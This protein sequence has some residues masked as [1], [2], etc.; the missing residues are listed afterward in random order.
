NFDTSNLSVFGP[1]N[2]TS[3][4]VLDKVT[5]ADGSYTKFDYNG[6]AQVYKT[7]NYAQNDGLL[8]YTWRNIETPSSNQTDCPRFTQTKTKIANFNL[9]QYGAAQEIVY[10]NSITTNQSYSLPDSISG[11][12]TKIEMSMDNDPYSSV[13]KIFVGSSG[14]NEGLPIATEDWATENSTSSRKRWTW[15]NWTQDD[16]T[17]SYIVNP[18]VTETRVG[19]TTNTKKTQVDY[20]LQTGTNISTYGLTKEV[21][22]YDANLSTVLKTAKAE[23]IMDTAYTSR[24]IIGLPS[25]SELYEGTSTLMSKVTYAYDEGNFSDTTL[26]QNISPIQHND[27]NYSSSFITGRGNLTS[28]TRWD[29]NYPTTSSAAVTASVKYNTAGLPVAQID[30]L[31][32]AVQISYADNFNDSNN[33][34]NTYAYPTKI[35]EAANTDTNN[36]YSQV[37]Y[38][39]DIG[40]NVW[41]KSPKPTGNTSGK[42]TTREFDSIGRLERETIVNTDA[43]TRYEYPT[44]GVQSKVYSTVIDTNNNGADSSDEVL[45]E[46]WTDGAGRVRM[47]KTDNPGSTGGYTGAI[48]EYD[49]LGQVR[50][51]SVPTEISV[52]STTSEWTPAGDD[53]NRGW[54]WTYQKYDWKGR[55]T[56]IINTD[57][58]DS[59]TLNDSDQLFSYDGCGCAGGQVTTIE[60]ESVP[61][62]GQTYSARRKQKVYADILGRIYKTEIM[63][64]D[65]STVYT[66]NVNTYNGRDQMTNTRQYAGTTSSSTYQDVTMTY[67]GHGRM[68][69]RH[70][71]IEDANTYTAWNYN[72]DDSIDDVT[73]PRGA[74]TSFTYNSRGLVSG[75]GYSVPTGSGIP[76]PSDV[77]FTYDAVGNRTQ[78]TDGAGTTDYAYNQLSQIISETKDFADTLAD[79]PTSHYQIQYAYNL[80]G[81]LKSVTDPFGQ[82][83]DYTQDKTGRLTKVDGSSF[84]T[85]T[86]ATTSYADGIKYRAWGAVKELTYKTDDNA[87]VAMQYDNRFR[88][89]QYEVDTSVVSSGHMKKA[90]FS[91]SADS[92]PNT[93]TDVE[94][95]E[96]NRTFQYDHIG[97]LTSNTFGT[98]TVTPYT[99]TN[100]YDSFSQLTGRNTTHWYANNQFT[101]TFTNG[102]ESTSGIL[103]TTYDAAGNQTNTGSRGDSTYQTRE[104]DAANRVKAFVSNGKRRT[105]RF[106]YIT[107]KIRL[108]QDYDGDGHRLKQTEAVWNNSTTGWVDTKTS[109]Q[110]WSTVLGSYLSEMTQT[111]KKS[112]TKVFAGGAVIAEQVRKPGA[113]TDIDAVEW[114]HADPVS[115]ST[116]RVGKEGAE[117]YRTEYE[118]LGSQEVHTAGD[119]EDYPEPTTPTEWAGY[120]ADDPQWQC[121]IAAHTG[122]PLPVQ[123]ELAEQASLEYEITS[124]E[125]GNASHI[126]NENGSG[127]SA[128]GTAGDNM[129]VDSTSTSK[130]QEN[131]GSEE[132]VPQSSIPSQDGKRQPPKLKIGRKLTKEELDVKRKIAATGIFD[133]EGEQQQVFDDKIPGIKDASYEGK[134]KID[135]RLPSNLRDQVAKVDED[136]N[137][138]AFVKLLLDQLKNLKQDYRSTSLLRIFDSVLV[139]EVNSKQADP[140]RVGS[141]AVSARQ[142]A[143]GY[144]WYSTV[145]T[146]QLNNTLGE[147][148][149]LAR[150]G[151]DKYTDAILDKAVKAIIG[152]KTFYNITQEQKKAG[153]EVSAGV[154]AHWVM[155]TACTTAMEN[156]LK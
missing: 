23:Y 104:Y 100:T 35:I 71:P 12:A 88:V 60:G 97:R 57:G 135:A 37:K 72:A 103:G 120:K 56:R 86:G 153:K 141:G 80:S 49:I 93:M 52:N 53:S 21:R 131:V 54:L 1:A 124:K 77:S 41:A 127:S 15:T 82:E 55:V 126:S 10:N 134:Q 4:S 70:Y 7:S 115:G 133:N 91:Y 32:R 48:T 31:S 27:N 99:Q 63:N 66:T 149:H 2:S 118:P 20:Y 145:R 22:V 84:G 18:R 81:G 154:V 128:S 33:S 61:V 46:R 107:S 17:K 112:K 122:F 5:F 36:N 58:S 68:K 94:H 6:Y 113:S 3:I 147:L 24:R 98:S 19:D 139:F 151:D 76:D 132:V 125:T 26:S 92:R 137:C 129:P 138:R 40:A 28:T 148:I 16:I 119:E 155:S 150:A 42:E 156:A 123:C 121:E 43:Y 39:F 25:K 9:D 79:E 64:W 47:S 74:T 50:R 105:G 116:T 140:K 106:N 143:A 90:T 73:D 75:V 11:T 65:G 108:T 8:N 67:D 146:Q 130:P 62:P 110:L 152:D 38:R 89:S 13:T 85:G 44:N 30:P 95:S 142:G 144:V 78:M 96:F 136:V 59:S 34:R 109:Y 101:S 83:I 111:G 51:A 114:I 87:L 14:W 69:T 29:V 102:R 117:Y 45:A